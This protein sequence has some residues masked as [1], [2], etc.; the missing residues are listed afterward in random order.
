MNREEQSQLESLL[1]EF[2]QGSSRKLDVSSASLGFALGTKGCEVLAKR[3]DSLRQA[4]ELNLAGA[5]IEAGGLRALMNAGPLLARLRKLDLNGCEL[6]RNGMA[7]LAAGIAQ[8]AVLEELGLG[9][10]DVGPS[11][12][13]L[14]RG[15]LRTLSSLRTL[16]LSMNDFGDEGVEVLADLAPDTP[17]LRQ[18]LLSFNEISAEG[19][20]VLAAAAKHW[21]EL[22]L[23]NLA[24]NEIDD[25]GAE[26]IAQANLASLRELYLNINRLGTPGARAIAEASKVWPQL[27]CLS[28]AN[29]EIGDAGVTAVIDT[30]R[31]EPWRSSL[32]YLE[33]ES[34]SAGSVPIEVL[35]STEASV[36]R[37][38]AD[39]L[40][41]GGRRLNEVKLLLLGEGRAGKTHL[42]QRLFGTDPTYHNPGELQ[43]HDIETER[44]LTS[45]PFGN[46]QGQV[47]VVV[48]D[49]GGQAALHASHRLFL[50]DRRGLFV[51]VCDA[52]RTRHENR[53]DYW[54][55]LVR[56]EASE[57]SPIIVAVTK[58]DLLDDA[59]EDASLRRL[60]QLDSGEL[61]R[62]AGLPKKTPVVVVDGIGWS[63]GAAKAGA[64]DQ[65]TRHTEAL[66]RLRAVI[67]ESIQLVPDVNARYPA[68]FVNFVRW[69]GVAGFAGA[70]E[71]PRGWVT[72]ERLRE[73]ARTFAVPGELFGVALDIGHSIGLLHFAPARRA[74]RPGEALAEVVFNPEWVKTPTYRVIREANGSGS[75]GVLSW[76]QIE[77][78]LPAHEASPHGATLWE[79][80]PFTP[81]DRV[82][83]VDLMI[84][85]EL[86]FVIDRGSRTRRYFV[87]DHLPPRQASGPPGGDYVWYREFEWLPEAEFGRLLGR[88]HQQ[89][90]GDHDALWRDEITVSVGRRGK[91]TVRLAEVAPPA[92]G[93][94]ARKVIHSTI[95]AAMSGCTE[96]QALRLLDQLDAEL[97][98]IR[99][100]ALV[101]PTAWTELRNQ[102][103]QRTEASK[104]RVPDYTLYA[105]R[106]YTAVKSV[107][108]RGGCEVKSWPSLLDWADQIVKLREREGEH[109]AELAA[110]V[111]RARENPEQFKRYCRAA[112]CLGWWAGGRGKR[113][114]SRS[115]TDW[116]AEDNS[117]SPSARDE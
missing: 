114:V 66:A 97:R 7:E 101:G 82:N 51:I 92:P 100:E 107:K 52:T 12:L 35:R 20:K 69:I 15:R 57:H 76:E 11:G 14:L 112:G 117:N 54:L 40:A 56:H 109:D 87:P 50:S 42:R 53:L 19:A 24:G 80:L 110:A 99:G 48:W 72:T 94:S 18:A 17:G 108:D 103:Q 23:L 36:W 98:S 65:R 34:T 8:L 71:L 81:A 89:G 3:L 88:L 64:A 95:Y 67:E 22:E 83:V 9:A 43:T 113:K 75:R 102:S 79:R 37:L 1:D 46:A 4:E 30:L 90:L 31:R 6:G 33:L 21:Q 28:L 60:E 45:A 74:L 104:V 116:A 5:E 85:C 58:C 61:R 111:R 29:N 25:A 86:L 70:D 32:E 84:A 41:Q 44:W 115:A 55:R 26:A 49:F 93:A 13:G 63:R 2:A 39:E 10:A 47:K 59:G 16:D 78:L 91:M 106:V 68:S 27:S 73:A 77:S 96:N 105:V 62:S 38:Y